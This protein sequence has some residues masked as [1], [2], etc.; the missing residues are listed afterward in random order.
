MLTSTYLQVK[1]LTLTAVFTPATEEADAYMK[2]GIKELGLPDNTTCLYAK[3]HL[4][5]E[6]LNTLIK[7]QTEVTTEN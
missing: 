4:T 2:A 5:P 7:P 1:H 3:R 6:Y